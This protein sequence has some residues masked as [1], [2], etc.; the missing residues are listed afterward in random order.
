MHA[1]GGSAVVRLLQKRH[2]R[3]QTPPAGHRGNGG[4]GHHP[5][6]R[7]R[8]R[9][10][11]LH[12]HQRNGGERRLRHMCRAVDHAEKRQHAGCDRIRL[13]DKYRHG[14]PQRGHPADLPRS[15]RGAGQPDAAPQRKMAARHHDAR[16]GGL[17]GP[18]QSRFVGTRCHIRHAEPHEGGLRPF[19]HGRGADELLR[20]PLPLGRL[21]LRDHDGTAARTAALSG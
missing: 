15:R 14:K 5:D 18:H 4:A 21:E 11:A 13:H 10:A 12:S 16:S 1:D 9:T 6:G 19:L 8:Y 2:G 20:R 3:E 17:P 7:S